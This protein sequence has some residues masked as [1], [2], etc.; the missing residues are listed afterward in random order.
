[1]FAAVRD[2]SKIAY[3]SQLLIMAV[4]LLFTYVTVKSLSIAVASDDQTYSAPRPSERLAFLSLGSATAESSF[5][6]CDRNIPGPQT[7]KVH[8]E[9]R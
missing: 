5:C 9:M 8:L 6:S 4:Q 1:M 7:G 2:C 3:L